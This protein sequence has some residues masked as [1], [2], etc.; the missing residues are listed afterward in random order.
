MEGPDFISIPINDNTSKYFL[1]LFS[2]AKALNQNVKVQYN[3][4]V[5]GECE[6]L[7]VELK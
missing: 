2:M 3:T 7:F 1:T 5:G 6:V 4:T